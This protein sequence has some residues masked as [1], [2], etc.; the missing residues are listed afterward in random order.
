MG[1]GAVE[2]LKW[3][4]LVLM[5]GDHIDTALFDRTFWVLS[6]AGRIAMPLFAAVFGY[7]LARPGQ[8]IE[9]ARKL[10]N[11]LLLVGVIAYPFHIMAVAHNWIALNIL[12][13]FAVAV[14]IEMW[15]RQDR[16][17]NA[18]KIVA[19]FVLSGFVLEFAWVAPALVLAWAAFWRRPHSTQLLVLVAVYVGL[20]V[21]NGNWWC[22]LSLP[23]TCLAVWLDPKICRSRNLFWIYYPA[24]LVVLAVL[25]YQ[26]PI[27]VPMVTVPPISAINY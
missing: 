17:N 14:Q 22:F 20:V 5:T 4:A 23:I 13:A 15:W 3:I 16:S 8:S 11:K 9:H 25:V 1:N 27:Y 19:L 21:V 12:F 18:P 2:L 6:E 26:V 7:N 24:H 10:R